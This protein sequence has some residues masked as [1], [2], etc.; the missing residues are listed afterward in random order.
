MRGIVI[1]F[2]GLVIFTSNVHAQT[3]ADSTTYVH[4]LPVDEDDTVATFP[5][6]DFYP[7]EN[8]VKVSYE[9]LSKKFKKGVSK[10]DQF[11]GWEKSPIYFDKNTNRYL[12]EMREGND[13]KIYGFNENGRPV[14]YDEVSRNTGQ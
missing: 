7:N 3:E 12:I 10:I 2:F 5:Q 6:T 14:T 1:V 11:A 8:V 9:T 13:I 4:G